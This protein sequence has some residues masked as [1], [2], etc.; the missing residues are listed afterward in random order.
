[1]PVSDCN[2]KEIIESVSLQLQDLISRKEAVITYDLLCPSIQYPKVYMHSI[3]YN[4]MSNSLKYNI[5]NTPPIIHIKT[6]KEFGTT[7]LK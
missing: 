4:L 6:Y 5:P 7:F 1:L 2:F 3:L